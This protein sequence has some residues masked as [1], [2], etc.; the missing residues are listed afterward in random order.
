MDNMT[1]NSTPHTRA[2]I[3]WEQKQRIGAIGVWSALAIPEH[4]F[5][6]S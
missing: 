2:T 3:E 1:R 6:C 5:L 4:S